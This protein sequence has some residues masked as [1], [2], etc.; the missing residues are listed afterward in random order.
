MFWLNLTIFL[1]FFP[2]SLGLLWQS[3]SLN[4]LSDQLISFAFFLFSLEQARMAIIDLKPCLFD[5]NKLQK[6]VYI[7]FYIVIFTTL[8]IELYG[9]Y[10]ALFSLGWGAIFVLISQLW[11]N[12]FAQIKVTET[13]NVMIQDYTFSDKI[14]VLSADVIALILMSL[15]VMNFYP[16]TIA[17]GMLTITLT[18]GTLKYGGFVVGMNPKTSKN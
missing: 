13:E 16:L 14:I 12:C 3:F 11:F 7:N 17:L 9:F 10:L 2:T 8:I 5:K 18:F 1:L 4:N 15:W 6:S